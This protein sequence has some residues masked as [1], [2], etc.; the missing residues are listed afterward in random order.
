MAISVSLEECY[1]TKMQIQRDVALGAYTTFKIGGRARMLVEVD[2]EET[3]RQAYAYSKAHHMR[4][5]VLGGGSNILFGDDDIDA[6]VLVMR[7]HQ[8]TARETSDHLYL[9]AESG[10]VWD[11][12][13]A[14]TT[15][16]GYFG[17]ENLSWIPGTMGGATVQNIGAYGTELEEVVEEVISY[18]PKSDRIITRGRDACAFRYRDSV[19][20]HE[21]KGE[22]VLSTTLRLSKHGISELSY[23][24]IKAYVKRTGVTLDTSE[25]VRKAV[26][27]IRTAKLPDLRVYGTAGSF[28]KNPLVSLGDAKRLRDR[29]PELPVYPVT[30]DTVKVSLGYLLDHA[31]HLRGVKTGPVWC[32][33]KQAL[34]IVHD[35]HAT[36]KHVRE[37][38]EM[39][40]MRMKRELGLIIEPEVIIIDA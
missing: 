21:A 10:C 5:F 20:K 38:I 37:F 12:I 14:Y 36:G 32:Y 23:P 33:D 30:S 29:Y 2:T 22:V 1:T 18:D 34:V 13:V 24:D 4:T 40:Q 7:M 28:F 15:T 35:G 6:M 8:M 3:L 16:R 26:I 19:W 17:I 25:L 11:D 27:A 39:I 9:T 31:L